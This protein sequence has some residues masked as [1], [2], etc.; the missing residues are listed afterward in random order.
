[1]ELTPSC[2]WGFQAPEI[3]GGQGRHGPHV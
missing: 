1:M 3:M 2:D